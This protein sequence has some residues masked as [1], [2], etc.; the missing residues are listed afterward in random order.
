MDIVFNGRCFTGKNGIKEH[1]TII[2][3]PSSSQL[4]QV[5]NK[6][7]IG[8]V[9]YDNLLYVILN[10]YEKLIEYQKKIVK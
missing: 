5:Q 3:E 4:K 9:I 10:I 2:F 8:K 1:K 6:W 7:L